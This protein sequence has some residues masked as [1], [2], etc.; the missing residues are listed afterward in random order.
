MA[1]M[2]LFKE[3]NIDESKIIKEREKLID[4]MLVKLLKHAN[5]TKGN[6]ITFVELFEGIKS[7][8]F[9]ANLDIPQSVVKQR[10]EYLIVKEFCKRNEDDRRIYHYIA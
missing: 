5:S 1:L 7:N 9:L 2:K 4:A 3:N 10:L 8:S 6:C